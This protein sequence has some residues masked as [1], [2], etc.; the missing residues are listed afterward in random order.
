MKWLFIFCVLVIVLANQANAGGTVAH[1]D[2]EKGSVDSFEGNTVWV[3]TAKKEIIKLCKSDL[4]EKTVYPLKMNQVVAYYSSSRH[5][6]T[7]D[8]CR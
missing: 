3:K 8:R 6:K 2:I 1:N 7:L 5:L 4:I